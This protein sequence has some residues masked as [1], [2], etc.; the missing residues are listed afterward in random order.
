MEIL[1]IVDR[2]PNKIIQV[3]SRHMFARHGR[4]GFDGWSQPATHNVTNDLCQFYLNK[5][6]AGRRYYRMEWRA[7]FESR[8]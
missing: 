1:D 8:H 6:L 2:H 4:Y 3:F 5:L 7:F